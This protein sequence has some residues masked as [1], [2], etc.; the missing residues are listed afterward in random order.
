[1]APKRRALSQAHENSA[2]E[3]RTKRP[4]KDYAT[5]SSS[6][7]EE[8]D[9]G[10]DEYL[11]KCILDENK[12]RYLIDWE[13]PW[14]P[15][16]EPKENANDLAVQVWRE[17]KRSTIASEEHQSGEDSQVQQSPSIVQSIESGD[18][19]IQ[20]SLSSTSPNPAASSA[21]CNTDTAETS[22]VE[23]NT[24]APV[25]IDRIEIPPE[26]HRA[27]ERYFSCL[28]VT[29][30]PQPLENDSEAP[31]EIPETQ[32]AGL[33]PSELV[34]STKRNRAHRDQAVC[35]EEVPYSRPLFQ[36]ISRSSIP[37]E[38][39]LPDEDETPVEREGSSP[40][41]T[42]PAGSTPSSSLT[43][44]STDQV[45]YSDQFDCQ[46]LETKQKSEEIDEIAETQS[47]TWA[48][49]EGQ[50]NRPKLG[51]GD[52]SFLSSSQTIRREQ[53]R[54]LNSTNCSG[55]TEIS[56]SF[57]T[58][59]VT[60]YHCNSAQESELAPASQNRER[61]ADIKE[62]EAQLVRPGYQ[63]LGGPEDKLEEESST[64]ALSHT[65][66]M[67]KP[68][69]VPGSTNAEKRKNARAEIIAKIEEDRNS[70]QSSA[71][72][73]ESPVRASSNEMAQPLSRGAVKEH[74]TP[75]AAV[76]P[77]VAESFP[78]QPE[79]PYPEP[80][81]H[82]VHIIHP[83]ALTVSHTEP[84]RGSVHLGSSEFAISLPMDSRVKDDYEGVL[85][86]EARTIRDF[87]RGF[88]PNSKL[89]EAEH[90][91]LAS[92]VNE[93]LEQLGNVTTHPDLN[94]IEHIR[95]SESDLEQEASWGEYSSSKFLLLGYLLQLASDRDLHFVVMVQTSKLLEIL[96]RYLLGKGL[97]YTRSRHEMGPGTD[98]EL[99]MAKDSLSF[100]IQTTRIDRVVQTYKPP[101]VIIALDRSFNAQTPSVEHM[102]TT[103]ARNG[104][105]LPAI[106]LLISNSGEHIERCLPDV[107]L[108]QR[109]R[110]LIHH[111]THLLDAVGDLQ[112][113]ALNVQEDVEQILSCLSSDNFNAHWSLPFIEPLHIVEPDELDSTMRYNQGN[114]DPEGMRIPT[115]ASQK[116]S[117]QMEE[118]AEQFPKRQRTEV[119]Q[120]APQMTESSNLPSRTLDSDSRPSDAK[121][122]QTKSPQ[123]V[124]LDQL[125]E[126]LTNTESRLQESGQIL[127]ELQHRYETR[128]REMH[129][130]RQE[131]DSLGAAKLTLE[132]RV[133]KQRDEIT[134]LK[135]E[136]TELKRDLT[137]AR[138]TIKD[139]GGSAAELEGA[140]EEVRRLKKENAGLE[141]RADYEKNQ[142]EYTREQYQNASTV[143][144]QSGNEIRQLKAENETLTRKVAGEASRLREL[145]MKTDQDRHLSRV[146]EL[147][148]TLANRDD[149]LRKKEDELCE[150]RKN[151]P[152]TRSTS[153]QP[154]SPKWTN[155]RPSSPGLNNNHNGS[156][157]LG[158]GSALRFSSE[159][160]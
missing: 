85:R 10:E 51:S 99:S 152:S 27:S 24:H 16:W 66:T 120:F 140:N 118:T 52:V 124:E 105:L 53:H 14:T 160:R 49:I 20:A 144:A 104:N 75:P 126:S 62:S 55:F 108:L 23:D 93:V 70:L 127:E 1:M 4:R 39:K 31:D 132:Q 36:Y 64:R 89:S 96:E 33:R 78:H 131:R 26:G 25:A 122:M 113:D 97:T 159:M 3:P 151:R 21:S 60:V 112:D 79:E 103:Y 34:S 101:S 50:P 106:R 82:P 17:K 133:E 98:L 15:T 136:R 137:Q 11:V 121:S 6:E 146:Q 157:S 18:S 80:E 88:E 71:R 76:N 42:Y 57:S 67:E 9:I 153:T 41:S 72:P 117:A 109:L 46:Q 147:E 102:R 129:K 143:A 7:S 116:R 150:I 2:P 84:P 91:Q 8:S 37:P 128:T 47:A 100:G 134:K 19:P 54:P 95:Y 119:M 149:L 69:D 156:N 81:D 155:S 135:D 22:A 45:K 30:E 110:L 139:G 48:D 125:K 65:A 83:S 28:F 130:I 13:G 90:H 123:A 141:R 56:S 5:S 86:R 29:P 35:S 77:P 114:G 107:P 142:G 12:F 63:T 138:E 59:A 38:Y 92:K 73:S 154:R 115:P 74:V 158:R 111:T 94:M 68:S 40:L 145:N 32:L 43:P 61:S 87:M 58:N 44:G 148:L